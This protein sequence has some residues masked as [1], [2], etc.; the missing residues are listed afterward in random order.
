MKSEGSVDGSQH[1]S[2][3][4]F[5]MFAISVVISLFLDECNPFCSLFSLQCLWPNILEVYR[6]W[7]FVFFNNWIWCHIFLVGYCIIQQVGL[8]WYDCM[9]RC[10]FMSWIIR[11]VH[12]F[13][14]K[15]G[16]CVWL[17]NW[18][19]GSRVGDRGC[20]LGRCLLWCPSW[21]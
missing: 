2:K 3:F 17:V 19:L 20:L 16:A 14:Y 6:G 7:N 10:V 15:K 11:R 21:L 18:R 8:S 13:D 1:W 5:L 4:F 9:C 12:V